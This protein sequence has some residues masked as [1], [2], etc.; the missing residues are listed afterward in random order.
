MFCLKSEGVLAEE[1]QYLY[2]EEIIYDYLY[3]GSVE[4]DLLLDLRYCTTRRY[5]PSRRTATV[6]D[7]TEHLAKTPVE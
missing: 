7:R 1:V 3:S 5:R 2:R 4:T 6:L